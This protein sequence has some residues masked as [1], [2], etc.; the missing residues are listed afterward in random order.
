MN[1]VDHVTP[2]LSSRSDQALKG[3]LGNQLEAGVETVKA[4]PAGR[5]PRGPRRVLEGIKHGTTGYGKGCRCDTCTAAAVLAVKKYR[6]KRARS[7][8]VKVD[9][10]S[11]VA[12]LDFAVRVGI[13]LQE[14]DARANLGTGYCHNLKRPG[15]KMHRDHRALL[16]RALRSLVDERQERIND[17]RS[18]L[19]FAEGKQPQ[20]KFNQ[21]TWP[22]SLLVA[23]ID[24]KYGPPEERENH[25]D[26]FPSP[27]WPN[28][29]D[30]R[31]VYRSE[32]LDTPRVERICQ[33]MDLY[34][35]NIYG[36]EWWGIE[37][38]AS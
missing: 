20:R 14:V 8:R 2:F 37:E 25:P 21:P 19:D 11:V 15:R 32:V 22:T 18:A 28:D 24:K 10:A 16:L 23:A 33:A 35:E 31:Y 26:L 17:L 12:V 27:P 5:G 34:P 7:G 13:L 3:S 4:V 6:V 29:A 1:D 38:E 9:K 36:P 30:R